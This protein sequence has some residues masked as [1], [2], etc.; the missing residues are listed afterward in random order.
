MKKL[1]VKEGIILIVVNGGTSDP[2]WVNGG[3]SD[4]LWV[5]GGTSEETSE[6][7]NN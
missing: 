2:L 6:E 7:T 5:N 1:I 4:P 3:T